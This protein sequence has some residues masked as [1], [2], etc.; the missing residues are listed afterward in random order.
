MGAVWKAKDRRLGR[1][2]ALK[3]IRGVEP[4]VAMRFVQ[5]ARAQARIGHPGVCKVYEVGEIAG[6]AYIAMQLLEGE[7]LDRAARNLS[8]P[9]K[10]QV[11]RDVA[12]AMH[13]AHKLGV[14]H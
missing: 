2:V 10:V 9:E 4:D 1:V 6:R 5:E 8:M 3:F 7:R 11:L 13:E 14:I 12:R